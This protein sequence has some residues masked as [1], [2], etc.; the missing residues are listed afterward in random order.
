MA[1]DVCKT[2]ELILFSIL[3]N[4]QNKYVAKRS[5]S[6]LIKFK[7]VTILCINETIHYGLGFPMFSGRAHSLVR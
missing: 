6:S 3:R 4:I 1:L 2:E 7:D 5:L